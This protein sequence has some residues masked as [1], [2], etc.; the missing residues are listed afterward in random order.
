MAS[1]LPRRPVFPRARF[2]R[3]SAVSKG[4]AWSRLTGQRSRPSDS[5][6]GVATTSS[7]VRA[8]ERH[9]RQ[10][11]ISVRPCECWRLDCLERRD[12]PRPELRLEPP[13]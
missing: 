1:S 6:A 3:S 10:P 2:T 4:R 8:G 7:P 9:K 13:I 11:P 5:A 12:G